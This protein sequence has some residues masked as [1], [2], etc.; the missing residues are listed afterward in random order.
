MY[1]DAL[2]LAAVADEWHTLLVGARIDAI[3]QPTEHAIAIQCYAPGGQGQGGHNHWLYLSAHPQLARAHI[4][5][6]KPAKIVSEPPPFVMLLRKHLEGA[7]IGSITQPRWERVLE[8]VVNYRSNL[9]SEE[10]VY[11]RLV[12]E[13]MGRLSNIILCD[14]NGVI[15]GSLKRVSAEINRYR[16]IAAGVPYVPPPPQQRTLAGQTLP[17]LEP[18]TL[19]AAQLTECAADGLDNQLFLAERLRGQGPVTSTELVDSEPQLSSAKKRKRSSEQPKL[20]QLLT[21]HVLGMSPL[22]AREAV[23]RTTEDAETTWLQADERVWQELSWNVRELA[24]LYDTHEWRPQLVQRTYAGDEHATQTLP[25]AFAVYV[26]EHY[27]RVVGVVAHRV[28][29]VNALL[30]E[31]YAR[32]EWRDAMEGVRTPIRKVLQAQRERCVRK[33]ALLQQELAV[34]QEAARYRLQADLLLAYQHEVQQGQSSVALQNFSDEA[35]V[36]IPLDPRFDAVG[37]ANR[38]YHKY[39]K[40]RRALE[41]VP[42]QIEHNAVELATLEQLLADLV[43]AETPAEVALVKAEVQ[44]AGYIRGKVASQGQKAHKANK[45]GKGGKQSK[46]VTPGGGVPL[47]VQSRD[48]FTLVVGKNSRQNEEVTFRQAK[49]NDIWLHARGVPGAHVIIK[50]AGSEVPHATI[51]QAASLAAYYSQARGST[52]VP[53]DYTLQ[54]HVRHMKGG[55]PGMVVYDREKTVYAQSLSPPR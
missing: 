23:Y 9:G 34:S 46:P 4:T 51:M 50:A 39:H 43:L 38:L 54:R 33:A 24:T 55:G 10:R 20:W 30:D 5:A 44:V 6:F 48:G 29:S 52:N 21:Q 36:T 41:L 27:S 32:A 22:L 1:V 18:T 25:L 8:I 16:V 19:T 2:T 14:Q 49:A 40:L 26:L 47:Y 11:F 13:I 17:R 15:V 35:V 31:Y 28:S 37:N 12:V 42:A 45:K 53:V 7:R 3:I